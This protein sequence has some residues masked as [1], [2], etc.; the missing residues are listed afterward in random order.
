MHF[1]WQAALVAALLAVVLAAM[2]RRSANERYLVCC[3]GLGVMMLAPLVTFA[4]VAGTLLP[5]ST[6]PAAATP[7]VTDGGRTSFFERLAPFLPGL[8][9]CWIAGVAV[10][11]ARLGLH[12]WLAHHLKRHGISPVPPAWEHVV[13][14]LRERLGVRRS[15]RILES[16][17][18]RV[19]TLI[20][21]LEPVILMPT[22]AWLGL[23]SAQLRAI[24]AHE[25]AHVRRHDYL[26]NLVQAVFESLFFY[27]PAVWWLSA[28]LRVERE[29]CCD[30]IAVGLGGGRLCYAQALSSLE[31]LRDA[32]ALDGSAQPPTALASTGGSLMNRIRR[33]AGVPL[34]PSRPAGGWLVSAAL[35]LAVLAAGSTMSVAL[36][37]GEQE[38]DGERAHKE[39]R[40]REQLH[41]GLERVNLV[42]ILEEH[43]ENRAEI[44]RTLRETGMTNDQLLHVLEVLGAEK[45]VFEAVHVEARRQAFV[46]RYMERAH[47]RIRMG[48]LE[49]A[50]TEADAHRAMALAEFEAHAHLENRLTDQDWKKMMEE[51]MAGARA[52]IE[53]ALESG[54]FTPEQAEEALQRA[55]KKI[56]NSLEQWYGQHVRE[57]ARKQFAESELHR[58]HD[59]IAEDIE[60]GRISE[61]EA[62]ERLSSAQ[63]ELDD[64]LALHDARAHERHFT[65]AEA[66]MRDAQRKIKQLVEIGEL[67]EAEAARKLEGLERELA[68]IHE[69][70]QRIEREGEKARPRRQARSAAEIAWASVAPAIAKAVEKGG[71]PREQIKKLH[72]EIVRDIERSR[73]TS[74]EAGVTEA[75]VHDVLDRMSVVL[76]EAGVPEADV[77]K[78]LEMA[79]KNLVRHLSHMDWERQQELRRKR[80]HDEDHE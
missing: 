19:P 58:L 57:I 50:I 16:S 34:A 18:A 35:T 48:L 31:E 45:D 29:Y 42:A 76:E 25:L 41:W 4:I 30:D 70:R 73:S 43:D 63:D 22:S 15:V 37:P 79:K 69:H 65:S 46:G 13:G 33:L 7:V 39:H 2:R 6:L 21:Y 71:L 53:A 54:H 62:K 61:A 77:R 74:R 68:Q 27:H 14:E 49:G 23:T 5:S 38:H 75:I 47:D 10:S 12:I 80:E 3:V 64:W 60:L 32:A 51:K 36:T 11:Q 9:L 52:E 17:L 26:V 59:Q 72:D 20:G 78:A 66:R 40:E 8:T 55:R 44:I 28:R 24:I 1:V 56:G 67:T